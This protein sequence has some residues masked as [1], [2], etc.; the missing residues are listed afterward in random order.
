MAEANQEMEVDQPQDVHNPAK[1]EREMK[2][3]FNLADDITEKLGYTR[4]AKIDIEQ[5]NLVA[6]ILSSVF[7]YLRKRDNF[8]AKEK[9]LRVW[10]R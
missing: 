7:T 5:S 6:G 9:K 8:K 4:P 2:L 1:R 10:R 3:L